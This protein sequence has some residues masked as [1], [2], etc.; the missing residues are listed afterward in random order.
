MNEILLLLQA[1]VCTGLVLLAWRLDRTRLYGVMVL[2]LILIS[3]TGG[4]VIEIF[5]HATN[6]GNVLYGAVF[7]ATY[8]LIERYGKQEG[9]HAI[10]LSIVSLIFF[11]ILARIAVAFQGAPETADFNTALEQLLSPSHRIALA[12]LIA[13][14]CSQSCNVALYLYLKNNMQHIGL[15]LRANTANLFAQVLDSV[16]FFS[17]AFWGVVSPENVLDA[18][19][20]GLVIKVVFMATAS[21]LLYMNGFEENDG[22]EYTAIT[23]R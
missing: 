21:L 3:L 14:V 12:S 11:M 22:P 13:F 4:K 16:L 23:W 10:R 20:T 6:T 17:I 15:W 7:L 8:F 5:G 2:F 9:I 18:L 19:L 1:V